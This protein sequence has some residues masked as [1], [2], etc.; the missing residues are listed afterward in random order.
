[1][2]VRGISQRN[3]EL[4]RDLFSAAVH[5]PSLLAQPTRLIWIE[6]PT[7]GFLVPLADMIA[8]R[9]VA[10]EAGLPIHLD[11]ARIFNAAVGLA[12]TVETLTQ[13]ADSVMF[14]FSKGLGAPVGSVLAGSRDF[15]ERARAMRQLLGGGMRQAGVL[16]AAGLYALDHNVE[17]LRD[18]HDNA[19]L[20]ARELCRRELGR[21]DREVV[22][23]NMFYLEP[24]GWKVSPDVLQTRMRDAGVAVNAPSRN[25]MIRFVTHLDVSSEDVL[26]AAGAIANAVA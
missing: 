13:V 5:G 22:E 4:L 15:I 18:D 17:R 11:G 23:T 9:A 10:D 12:V 6:Q 21:L 26:A 19:R 25:G 3:G 14:C 24:T 1:M 2:T 20:L 16:A 7:R 8:I